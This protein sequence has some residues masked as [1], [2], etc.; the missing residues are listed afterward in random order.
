MNDVNDW[1]A[2]YLDALEEQELLQRLL[3]KVSLAAEGGD[4]ELDHLLG[5]LREKLRKGRAD[6][7]QLSALE[8]SLKGYDKRR[9]HKIQDLDAQLKSLLDQGLESSRD[10]EKKKLLKKAKKQLKGLSTHPDEWIEFMVSLVTIQLSD[11]P[12][13][14]DGTSR[15]KRWLLGA[16]D[17]EVKRKSDE[18]EDIKEADLELSAEPVSE[19]VSDSPV[20]ADEDGPVAVEP[21]PDSPIASDSFVD[22]APTVDG[23]SESGDWSDAENKR[24]E[25]DTEKASS[26][27][28]V[29]QDDVDAEV[30][31]AEPIADSS[32]EPDEALEGQFQTRKEAETQD[33]YEATLQRPVHEP[34]FSRISDKVETILTDLVNHV[35]AGEVVAHKAIAVRLRMAKGLNWYELVPTLEDIRDLVMQAYLVADNE[36]R[37]YLKEV[38]SALAAI[39]IST[40]AVLEQVEED[41]QVEEEF[42]GALSRQLGS[43]S[44]TLEVA[45][46][47]ESL[48]RSVKDHLGSLSEAIDTRTSRKNDIDTV[49]LE[50]L[51]QVQSE[52]DQARK[53]A[54]D[55]KKELEVQRKRATT[56][57]LTGLPNR[58]AY[59]TRIYEEFVRWQRYGRP[60]SFAVCDIDYFKKINDTYGHATG[61]RV[62]KVL[63]KSLKKRMRA[64]DFVGRIGGEEFALIMP[65]TSA[66]GALTFLNKVREGIAATPFRYKDSPIA[67]TIS[68][69]VAQFRGEDSID[70]VFKR[71]D[72]A[73]YVAKEQGRNRCVMETVG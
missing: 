59:N 18:P 52:L 14:A 53:S 56:D 20:E 63:A 60:L 42:H 29:A 54:V 61:D 5:A 32:L 8:A 27:S 49:L 57:S 4:S 41:K 11:K 7:T 6:F 37:A 28:D 34:A 1:K 24:S 73:L 72:K 16:S 15:W 10:A 13:E 66:D 19:S 48:K 17:D 51:S 70:K 58:E 46:E 38:E 25:L 47:V 62:L 68:V 64:A 40:G 36:Y 9:E 50:K 65:E 33:E 44:Q 2:K 30:A 55:A 35:D 21:V 39:V 67:I 3:A 43:L 45:Q 69:G 22:D 12:Q 71:A 23:A 26:A 31:G